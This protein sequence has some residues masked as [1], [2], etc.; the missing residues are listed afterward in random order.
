MSSNRGRRNS[1]LDSLD[2]LLDMLDYACE[3]NIAKDTSDSHDFALPP[4]LPRAEFHEFL[5]VGGYEEAQQT[6]P[7]ASP[8]VTTNATGSAGTV[9]VMNGKC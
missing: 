9:S 4:E 8:I 1:Q 7:P 2:T 5:D 6:A 3:H